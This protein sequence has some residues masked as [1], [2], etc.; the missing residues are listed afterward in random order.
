LAAVLLFIKKSE[1]TGEANVAEKIGTKEAS[2]QAAR[3][4]Q[5]KCYELDLW[6]QTQRLKNISKQTDC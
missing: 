1:K 2:K 5:A 6:K 3:A 4:M